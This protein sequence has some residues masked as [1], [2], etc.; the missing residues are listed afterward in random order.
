MKVVKFVCYGL[1]V[2]IALS[3]IGAMF[4]GRFTPILWFFMIVFFIIGAVIK[5]GK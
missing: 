3:N 2:V 5:G 1:G 4:S